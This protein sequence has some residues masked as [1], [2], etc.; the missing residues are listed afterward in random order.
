MKTIPL[1]RGKYALVDDGDFEYL[2][3][4]KWHAQFIKGIWYAC[5]GVRQPKIAI[6]I[7]GKVVR[8]LMHRVITGAT[9]RWE[10]VDH[11]DHDGLNNQRHNLRIVTNSQ[12]LRNRKPKIYQ[13][14]T[15]AA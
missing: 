4:W 6:G 9:G 2:N 15:I 14:K 8:I 3:Q 10:I 1:T 12:N 5:R 13:P 11:I 7:P